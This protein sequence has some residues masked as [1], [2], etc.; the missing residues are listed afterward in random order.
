[1]TN[2]TIR[3]PGEGE[4]LINMLGAKVLIRI[5]GRETNGCYAMIEAEQPPNSRRRRFTSTTGKTKRSRFCKV[6]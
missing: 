6:V 5:T 4:P 2:A 1:M 3:R